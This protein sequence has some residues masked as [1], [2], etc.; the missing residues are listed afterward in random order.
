MVKISGAKRF[1][2]HDIWSMTNEDVK[3]IRRWLINALK[4]AYL[5]IRFF[6][7]HRTMERA[8]ALTYYTLLAIVP[9]I[10]L[11][12][13]LGRG[14]GLQ[15]MV[16]YSLHQNL[17]GQEA[18]VNYISRFADAYLTQA[19]SSVVVG[20]GIV[21]LFYVVYSLI[22]N[23]ENV[24][25]EIWQQ[26]QGRSTLRKLTDY[27][28][29]IVLLPIVFTVITGGQI[30]LQTYIKT[31][32]IHYNHE[33][34]QSLL[35]MLRWVPYL[36]TILMLTFIYIVIPNCKVKFRNAFAAALI[37]GSA[38]MVFQWLYITGQIWVSKYNAIYGSFAAL[39]LFLLWI[40]MAWIICLYGAE[41]S[42]A[43]QNIQ[44]Y[45]FANESASLSR[46]DRDFLLV[47]VA[48]HVYRRFSIQAEA[49]TTE[50]I[51]QDLQL[52]SRL[53]GELVSQL[54]DLGAIREG[55]SP[56][57]SMPN[58]W[59]IGFDS[60]K[61]T[62]AALFDL[63]NTNGKNQLKVNHAEAFPDEWKTFVSMHQASLAK[64]QSLLLRDIRTED[65]KPL[66][67]SEVI[68]GTNNITNN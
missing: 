42:Y 6:T 19:K 8:S 34:S 40:Q 68:K 10:A 41:L 50:M 52:P 37:A 3:G 55:V 12:L 24:L 36:L 17:Q 32:L 5:S 45:D 61:F 63:L 22:N 48:A 33:L 30:F 35:E 66:T 27:V 2:T 46:R 65:F 43:A 51:G 53:T 9:A 54:A 23:V 21:M 47:L 18:I 29:I 58:N 20:V 1:L 31:D 13:G 11:F 44:N 14:F 38:F 67:K 60:D 64:G 49:P 26:K 4:A 16:S 28:S 25:N 57:V 62:I 7:A 56:D 59:T 39:P 15:S